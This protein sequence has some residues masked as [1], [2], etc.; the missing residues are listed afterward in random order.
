MKRVYESP[1]AYAEMFTP[2]EYVAACITG[3]IQCAYPGKKG[4]VGNPNIFDDF[5]GRESGWWYDP[6]DTERKYPHGVCGN[7]APLTFNTNTFSGYEVVNGRVDR[8]RPISNIKG[9]NEDNGTGTFYN[10]TWTSTDGNA[11]YYH[12]GRLKVNSIDSNRPNH[13]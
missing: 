5:N 7:D 12:K 9:W 6:N 1:R 2:D 13:S 11:T 8:N 10:I 3:I 4:T